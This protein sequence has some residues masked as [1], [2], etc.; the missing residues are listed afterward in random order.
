MIIVGITGGIA[1]YK[2]VEVVRS[3]V[4]AGQH[5]EVVAT[6][7]ALKFVG[8]PTLEALSQHPVHTSLY[9]D[10]SARD[11]LLLHLNQRSYR[12]SSSVVPVDRWL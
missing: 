6:E 4:L 8:V 7:A 9:D 1:A 3:L 12:I 5:V 11:R 10:N 2:A